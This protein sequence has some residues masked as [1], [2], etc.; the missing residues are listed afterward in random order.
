M[1]TVFM[2]CFRTRVGG[3]DL[4]NAGRSF[5]NK[6]QSVIKRPAVCIAFSGQLQFGEGVLFICGKVVSFTH[7]SPLPA[8]EI[9]LIHVSFRILRPEGLM[10]MKYSNDTIG[11]RS[12]STSRATA[13]PPVCQSFF[14]SLA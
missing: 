12:V 8:H 9:F 10:S 11:N 7:R 4:S 6:L 1:L 3:R 13:C 14:F 2:W 5:E